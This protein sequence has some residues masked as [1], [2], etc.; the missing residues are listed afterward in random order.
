[1]N[2][3]KNF[4][5]ICIGM[6]LVALCPIFGQGEC[7]GEFTEDFRTGDCVFSDRVDAFAWGNPYFPLEPGWQ[8]VLEGEEEDEEGDVEF[9]R[10]QI[11]VLDETRAVDG[12]L[13]RVVEEREWIDDELMEVSRNFYAIC[14]TTNDVFY[15]GEEV[16]FYEGG[17]IVNHE[18][19][20]LAGEDGAEPGIIMPGSLLL[21]ARYMQEIAPANDALDRAEIIEFLDVEIAGEEFEDVIVIEDSTA[22]EPDEPGEI[23]YFAPGIGN[24]RDEA[25]ELVEFGFAFLVPNRWL[26]HV[27]RFEGGFQTELRFVNSASS[28]ASMTLTPYLED[29][30][31]L[32]Q[33]QIVV[34]GASTLAMVSNELF[35]A[36]EVSHFAIEGPRECAVIGAY[37]AV[38]GVGISAEVR[39]SGS[40]HCSFTIFEGEW[41]GAF[42]DGFALVNLG[43][44]ASTISAIQ[45]SHDGSVLDQAV[46]AT[47]VAPNGKIRVVLGDFFENQPGSLIEVSAGQSFV[48]TVLRGT[49]PGLPL[50]VLWANPPIMMGACI[51]GS[52]NEGPE[53]TFALKDAKL[54]IEH[55]ATDEDTGFQGFA[56]G[57]PWDVLEIAGPAGAIVLVNSEGTF[58]GFGLTELFF[59][60]SEPEN[61]EVPIPDV[62]ARLPEGQY[63]FT[64]MMVDG[65][66]SSMTTMFTHRIPAGP[67]LLTPAD[68]EEDVDPQNVIVAWSPVTETF[69]GSTEI[70][71]V[72]YQVIVEIIEEPL[73][74]EGFAGSLFSAHV[75]SSITSVTIPSE[76]MEAGKAYEYEVLAI[77]ESGNQT[78]SSAEF[79]TGPEIEV[80][81][82]EEETPM[83]KA[84]KLLIEH[85]ATDEDTGFQAFADGDPWDQLEIVGP[86]GE[87]VLVSA[88]GGLLEFGLTELFFETS[89]P[90]NDEVPIP[91]VL[92][93]LP[94]GQYDFFGEM[95]DAD[96]SS[97]VAGF[98]HGIPAGPELLTPGEEE[99]DVNPANAVLSWNPVTET[100]EGSMDLL[101]VGYQVIV[102]ADEEPLFP[103]GFAKSLLSIHLPASVTSVT[104]PMEFLQ[105]DTD[106]EWEVLAIEASGNQ[107]LSSGEFT[108]E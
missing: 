58:E 87:I 30:Q 82:P 106:Y 9:I 48:V 72:G 83:L 20:W 29:G 93:R 80:A 31:A 70:N 62:L 90:E 16:D 40:S 6:G 71:I 38:S 105:G 77:E 74:T 102:E 52:G 53:E 96:E 86:G 85:N 14:L 99:E 41:G 91:D 108:T 61:A 36:N 11:T 92:A 2:I 79:F 51:T 57:D 22:L 35:G 33:V 95:V 50:A 100:I 27:T 1:M 28:D 46:L 3:Y 94:E 26:S 21:G 24:I 12:V 63:T 67:E 56:D 65:S 104:V 23:K 42:F 73:N 55:N 32:D 17:E 76:F 68:G 19:A 45:K 60:T 43:T 7:A 97:L 78:L 54:L 44:S 107:T 89:E 69:D 18:G 5:I 59:E 15:F 13:T 101:I 84:A 88:A 4:F 49:V 37:K 66:S 81:E 47:K 64:A 10:L 75:P 98:T 34:P 8:L 103:Q 25:L 39:E